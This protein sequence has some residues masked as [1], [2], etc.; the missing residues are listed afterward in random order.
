MTTVFFNRLSNFPV[1]INNLNPE[2]AITPR[3]EFLPSFLISFSA[4]VAE[5]FD[6]IMNNNF[7]P[8]YHFKDQK[9]IPPS[10]LSELEK[11]RKDHIS[12][13]ILRL[14]YCQT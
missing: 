12:H 5:C 1:G 7:L 3:M 4:L 13:F 11:R 9:K 2:N 14:A 8:Q 10:G 6:A